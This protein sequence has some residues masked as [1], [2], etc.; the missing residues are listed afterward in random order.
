M[1]FT[2]TQQFLPGATKI[3]SMDP[4]AKSKKK[5]RREYFL[6]VDANK[7]G[8]LMNKERLVDKDANIYYEFVQDPETGEI[9][10]RCQEP[11]TEHR[12]RGSAKKKENE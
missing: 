3:K 1:D 12:N 2:A 11:L 8:K 10:R 7:D 5:L 9:V 4:H 6:G